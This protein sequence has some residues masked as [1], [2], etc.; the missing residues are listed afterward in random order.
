MQ[1]K[2]SYMSVGIE[3]SVAQFGVWFTRYHEAIQ[4]LSVPQFDV[5]Y[6][7]AIQ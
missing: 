6:H 1:E 2:E 3:K 5:W 4:L 7:E